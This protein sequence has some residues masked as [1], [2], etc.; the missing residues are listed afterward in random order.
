[1]IAMVVTLP[2]ILAAQTLSTSTIHCIDLAFHTDGVVTGTLTTH[3]ALIL[4]Y[5]QIA[6][7]FVYTLATIFTLRWFAFMLSAFPF[8]VFTYTCITAI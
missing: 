5:A 7:I 6:A 3:P 4:A 2:A 8:T 1:M